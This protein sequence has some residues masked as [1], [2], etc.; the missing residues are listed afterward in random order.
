MK[1]IIDTFILRDPTKVGYWL[2]LGFFI[3]GLFFAYLLSLKGDVTIPF[4]LGDLTLDSDSYLKP[5]EAYVDNNTY[6][7]DYRMPGYGIIYLPLYSLFSKH[8]ALNGIIFLQ[9][10]ASAMSCYFLAKT[11]LLVFKSKKYFYWTFFIY[12]LSSYANMFDDYIMTESF[13]TSFLIFSIYLF[14]V[15]IRERKNTSLLYSGLF[16]TWVIFLRPVFAP[17]LFFMIILCFL[18]QK[19]GVKKQLFHCF[20][21]IIPF[22]I[23]DGLWAFRNFKTNNVLAPLTTTL[24]YPAFENGIQKPIF[25]FVQSWGGTIVYWEPNN[26][27]TWFGLPLDDK[28]KDEE[29]YTNSSIPPHIFTSKF[30]MDSLNNLRNKIIQYSMLDNTTTNIITSDLKKDIVQTLKEYTLSV[31]KERPFLYYFKAR[32]GFVPKFLILK[33][34]FTRLFKRDYYVDNKIKF[35]LKVFNFALYH[36]VVLFAFFGAIYL[37]VRKGSS[38]TRFLIAGLFIYI[39][40]VHP[41]VLRFTENRY[42]VP[43]WPFATICAAH[44]IILIQS[45]ININNWKA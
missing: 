6:S 35:L 5:I 30:N 13:T 22:L 44:I 32:L 11:T 31:K 26:H 39:A 17:V 45:K 9:Y 18:S 43:A 16:I 42:F 25:E 37:I 12:L 7:P 20:I 3:K 38:I 21:F 1:K 27:A 29:Y 15:W 40:L 36:L 24:Y 4:F 10:C 28:Y 41:I 8:V 23:I 14:T 33:N 34:D 19:E 2:F